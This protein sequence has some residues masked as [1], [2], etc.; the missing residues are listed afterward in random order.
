MTAARRLVLYSDPECQNVELDRRMLALIAS[1]RRERAAQGLGLPEGPPRIGY[2]PAAS[3]PRRIWF[4]RNR[5]R[6]AELGAMLEPYFGLESDY[7]PQALPELLAC[8][9]LHLSGGNTFHFLWCLRQRK[10][11]PVLRDYTARGGVLV[12]VSAGAVLMG[13]SIDVAA[14]CGDEPVPELHDTC[15]LGLVDFD[16]VPHFETSAGAAAMLNDH[17]A[18]SG[19]SICACPDGAGLIVEGGAVSSIGA[20]AWIPAK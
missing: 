20:V 16:F 18:R 2:L 15:G 8:D 14:L 19:R 10:L 1:G 5:A 6:Y 4:E 3:D 17:M 9:A 13:P 7:A 11:L 12:G